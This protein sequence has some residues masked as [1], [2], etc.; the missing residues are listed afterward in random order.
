MSTQ[1]AEA[2]RLIVSGKDPRQDR[3]IAAEA[4]AEHECE[5]S[6]K[7]RIAMLEALVADREKSLRKAREMLAAHE[8]AKPEPTA[9][10]GVNPRTGT[11]E[12]C[13]HQPSPSVFRDFDMKPLYAA[14]VA[15][16]SQWQPIETAPKDGSLL[17]LKEKWEDEPFIGQWV[18]SVYGDKWAASRTHY[19]TDGDACVT[20][21]IYSEAVSHWMPLPP[22]PKEQA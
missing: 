5:V 7:A 4:L 14:L 8:A 2:L 20:D 3:V 19:D 18:N 6:D 10:M 16:A 1:L 17:L 21:R 11:L 9:F 12:F 13:A 15:V 22:A